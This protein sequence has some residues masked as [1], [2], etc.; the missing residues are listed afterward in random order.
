MPLQRTLSTMDQIRTH[1]MRRQT[2]TVA[3]RVVKA[4]D[5][6]TAHAKTQAETTQA[7]ARLAPPAPPGLSSPVDLSPEVL[8]ASP[9]DVP[10]LPSRG[11]RRLFFGEHHFTE[12]YRSHRE[13]GWRPPIDSTAGCKHAP[14]V[15]HQRPGRRRNQALD[16]VAE[17]LNQCDRFSELCFHRQCCQWLRASKLT[18]NERLDTSYGF[19]FT[20]VRGELRECDND[21]EPLR[22]LHAGQGLF[23]KD[24]DC[25]TLP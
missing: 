9:E 5:P 20:V 18:Q 19:Y 16:L 21:G 24:L 13:Y 17:E 23:A 15:L 1:N 25:G 6:S 8:A 4:L 12:K 3:R 14:R 2:S 22:I 10:R 7:A 11:S